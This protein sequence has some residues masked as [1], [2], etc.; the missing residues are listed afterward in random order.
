MDVPQIK[1][2]GKVSPGTDSLAVHTCGFTE[3]YAAQ[4]E[5]KLQ[6]RSPLLSHDEMTAWP[7][8]FQK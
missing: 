5:L 8:G 7:I 2:F 4:L 1:W 6:H 3:T